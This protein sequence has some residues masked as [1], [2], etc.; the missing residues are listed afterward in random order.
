MTSMDD[1]FYDETIVHNM[2]KPISTAFVVRAR[3]GNVNFS[4]VVDFYFESL[5][6][7]IEK[8]GD[9]FP[10]FFFPPVETDPGVT[11]VD[12]TALSV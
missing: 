8:T 9:W 3:R 6:D 10:D 5:D 11:E 2:G 7:P 12:E 1:L 4:D